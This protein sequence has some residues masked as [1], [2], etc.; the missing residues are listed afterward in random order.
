MSSFTKPLDL[1]FHDVEMSERPFEL[2]TS[3]EYHIG[4]EG[5]GNVITV[6][7]G[8][9]TDFA[10]VPKFF[11]RVFSPVGAHGKAA[12]I[13]DWLCDTEKKRF[14][15][16]QAADIFG[17]A[18]EVLGVPSWRRKLMVKAVKAFGPRF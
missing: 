15:Y 8:Y 17:E 14:D 9:R 10:S 11:H 16:M 12:V 3:F 2:L 1:R 4:E 13:H 6:P 18:M 5:S 7:A